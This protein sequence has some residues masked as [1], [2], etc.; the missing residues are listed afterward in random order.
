MPCYFRRSATQT[1]LGCVSSY[2]SKL[3]D[4]NSTH[5]SKKPKLTLDRNVMPV[6]YNVNMYKASNNPYE[7]DIKVYLN[8]DWVWHKISLNKTDVDYI[9]KHLGKIKPSAPT[10]EK[11]FGT[12]YLRF[13]FDKDV[14]LYNTKIKEQTICS[15]DLGVNTDAT[16][17]I[18]SSDGTIHARKFINF[19]CDKDQ[20][21][22]L[23]NRIKKHQ[24]RYGPKSVK[25]KWAYATYLNKELS[26]KIAHTIVEFAELWNVDVIVFE[27]L[28]M[29]GSN[30]RGKNAQ[31][32]HLWR[33]NGI[34]KMVTHKAHKRHMRV[35]H[36]CA[37]GTSQLA[38][39]G[40]GKVLRGKDA[41]FD[42]YELCRFTNGKV[43]NCDLSAS[44]NIGARY[45]IRELLKPVTEKQRSQLFAKVPEAERR[46]SCTYN[47]LLKLN[48]VMLEL[49]EIA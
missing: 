26:V 1:A 42:T 29:K 12:Y 24:R 7:C 11:R 39:D 34:Q 25:R 9:K 13:A 15:I 6:F 19:A 23:C 22:H 27:H 35:S 37:W 36:I 14:K 10:L 43:Y 20:L 17:T 32:L 28:D 5:I 4:W 2:Q 21:W 41:G 48:S 18:M 44:Y 3:V 8:N 30:H 47:T 16:C 40:S 33:K 49:K 45:F 38:Y 46:T 31:K